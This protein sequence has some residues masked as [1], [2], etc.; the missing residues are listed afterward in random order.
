MTKFLLWDMLWAFYDWWDG[1]LKVSQRDQ[2]EDQ[3]SNLRHGVIE[4]G[5]GAWHH[6]D[7]HDVPEV[8]H[9]G[10]WVQE[11]ALIEDLKHIRDLDMCPPEPGPDT[12]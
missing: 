6:G 12:P 3:L 4:W 10:P 8:P 5:E 11:E 9:V 7:V 2:T 1:W